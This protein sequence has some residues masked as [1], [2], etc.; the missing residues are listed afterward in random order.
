M[1]KLNIKDSEI[2]V[3]KIQ[4]DIDKEQF[5]RFLKLIETEESKADVTNNLLEKIE[6]LSEL[7]PPD[8]I[9]KIIE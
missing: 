7:S 2:N 1:D 5:E 4:I 8:K 3:E 6:I 9:K